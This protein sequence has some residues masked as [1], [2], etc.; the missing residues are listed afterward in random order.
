VK[1][2]YSLLEIKLGFFPL[3]FFL[4][5]CTPVVEIDGEKS[6]KSWGSHDFKITPG[7][8]KIKIYFP[9]MWMSECGANEVTI[10]IQEGLKRKVSYYMWPF[11]FAKGSIHIT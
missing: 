1:T 9:Y 7:Q 5:L 3:A 10:D 8:H 11:V 2:E 6:Q 4:F